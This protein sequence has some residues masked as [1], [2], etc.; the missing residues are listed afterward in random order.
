M[1][2]YLNMYEQDEIAFGYTNVGVIIIQPKQKHIQT[3]Y[4][5]WWLEWNKETMFWNLILWNNNEV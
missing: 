1:E 4:F 2:W 5:F 3:V